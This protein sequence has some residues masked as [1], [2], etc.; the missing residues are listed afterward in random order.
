MIKWLPTIITFLPLLFTLF[1]IVTPKDKIKAIRILAAVGTGL[2]LV[3]SIVMYLAFDYSNP[4]FQMS[5]Q[6]PWIPMIGAEYYMAVDG[7]SIPLVVVTALLTF[8][9]IIASWKIDK[10][11]KEYMGMMVFCEIGMLG[12]FMALDF[13]L[14]YVFWEIVLI[15][16]YFL[17]AIWGGPRREYAAIKFFLFTFIGSVLML[18]GILAVYFYSGE[19]TFNMMRLAEATVPPL[20][21]KLAFLGMFVG[22][23]VKVPI[24]PFHT[25]L[26]DAHVEAPTAAS[27]LLAGVL[28]KMGTYAFVRIGLQVVP[29]GMKPFITMIAV[30][31][32][33]SIIYGALCAMVQTDLKKLVAYSSI[34]H[35]GYVMLGIA[36]LTPAGLN[37]AVLQ[38]FSHGVITGMLFLVVGLVY[39]RAKTRDI[40][41]IN[42][43]FVGATM[44]SGIW[45][46]TSLASFGLPSLA[47]FV[48]EFLVLIGTFPVYG[49]MT[50]IAA[51]GIIL[52]AGYLVWTI[53][54][55]CFGKPDPEIDW[56][57][58][59]ARE[60]SY[61]VPMMIIIVIVGVY[62]AL[63]T[64]MITP[65]TAALLTK[66]GGL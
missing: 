54:R 12:V 31:G 43:L 24:V 28:L 22:F 1:I 45:V 6:V 3:A 59:T 46:F 44:I 32:V 18:L 49:V 29:G 4:G 56:R 7:I 60:L 2:V 26:P 19:G 66:M 27:V 11:V 40:A 35:M 62:P 5:V 39:E 23:A 51:A 25:W 9:C 41:K 55:I 20:V 61:M 36:S 37:G 53:Q 14:F 38:M 16:M 33:I 47:G 30:L 15:P 48:G 17:I 64:N 65:T 21:L 8:V 57:D 42:G 58:A 63:L 52:T 34:S 50:G 10:R 13:L